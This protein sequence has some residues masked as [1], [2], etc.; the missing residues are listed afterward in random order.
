MIAGEGIIDLSRQWPECLV[1]DQ[2]QNN[3]FLINNF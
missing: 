2:E 1:H 3:N